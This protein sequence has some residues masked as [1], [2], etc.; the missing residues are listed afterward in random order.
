[1]GKFRKLTR[2]VMAGEQ[3]DALVEAVLGLDE[4]PDSRTLIELLRLYPS[5]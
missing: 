1:V 4:L 3:Q 2:G 5:S